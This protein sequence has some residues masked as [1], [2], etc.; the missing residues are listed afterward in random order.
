MVSSK[1]RL[2]SHRANQAKEIEGESS[3]KGISEF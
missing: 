1:S 2:D 3:I